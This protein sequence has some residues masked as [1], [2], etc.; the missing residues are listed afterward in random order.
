MILA[1]LCSYA[2]HFY[3]TVIMDKNECYAMV[4]HSL[5]NNS[6]QKIT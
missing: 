4:S 2:V 6:N 1:T 5:D 3:V